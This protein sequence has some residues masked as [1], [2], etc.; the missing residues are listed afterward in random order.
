MSMYRAIF[1]ESTERDRLLK[2]LNLTQNDFYRYRDCYLTEDGKIA[3]YT[4]GGGD[5]RECLCFDSF[6]TPEKDQ[7]KDGEHRSGCVVEIQEKN[8]THSWYDYDE[9][10]DYDCTYATFYFKIPDDILKMLSD[11]SPE[12]SRDEMW[13]N[14]FGNLEKLR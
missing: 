1:G 5:N 9:D 7:P 4:R 12:R 3:V 11:I 6:F 13:V 8:R 14:L 10:D 2:L